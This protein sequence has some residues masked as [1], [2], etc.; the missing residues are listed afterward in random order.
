M[1]EDL[2]EEWEQVLDGAVLAAAQ[3]AAGARTAVDVPVALATDN[4]IPA[5]L[6]QVRRLLE[7]RIEGDVELAGVKVWEWTSRSGGR[8]YTELGDR[9]GLELRLTPPTIRAPI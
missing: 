1:A 6:Q 2:P 8:A 3:A 9:I 4:A 5:R 7:N